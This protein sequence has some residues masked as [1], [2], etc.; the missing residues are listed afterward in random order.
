MLNRSRPVLVAH[1]QILS[2]LVAQKS[3]PGSKS[4]HEWKFYL[5]FPVIFTHGWSFAKS[6]SYLADEPCLKRSFPKFDFAT[7]AFE[8]RSDHVSY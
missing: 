2:R 4:T 7:T 1:P 8:S 5:L 3:E 6:L